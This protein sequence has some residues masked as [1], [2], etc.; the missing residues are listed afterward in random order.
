MHLY[1]LSFILFHETGYKHS[2]CKHFLGKFQSLLFILRALF[3][4]GINER[5]CMSSAYA[6]FEL[7]FTVC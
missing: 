7:V 1:F 5:L 4:L 2:H 3:P 6:C